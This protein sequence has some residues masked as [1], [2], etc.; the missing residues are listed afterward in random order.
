MRRLDYTVNFAAP[1]EKIYQDFVSRHY[2]E[3]LMDAYRAVTPISEI[4]CFSSDG[5]GTRIV[6]TQ[7]GRRADLPP[8]ARAVIPVDMVITREQHFDPYDHARN[9]ATGTYR[10]SI[11]AVP[12]N[13]TG[14]S[15][16]NETEDGCQLRISSICKIGIPLIGGRVEELIMRHLT[17]VFEAE[18]EFTAE[19]VARHH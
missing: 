9:R 1:P 6:F 7:T 14:T 12:G 18:H 2:W 15:L 4:T 19:W 8:F 11:P 13:L 17:V 16:I 3:G 5:A 10:A